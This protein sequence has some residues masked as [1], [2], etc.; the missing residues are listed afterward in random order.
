MNPPVG[1]SEN[2]FKGIV[3][4]VAGGALIT[5]SD[6]IMKIFAGRL[7]PGE[8]LFIRNSFTLIAIAL[9]AL[10]IGSVL[11]LR[12]KN[13]R[14]QA[15]RAGF[16]VVS[17]FLFVAGIEHTPLA[18]A[19]AITFTGPLIVTALAVPM[20]GEQVGWRRWL[21]VAIGFV[22]VVV[23]IRPGTDAFTWGSIFI[24]LGSAGG[25]MRDIITRRL[26]ATET[27]LSILLISSAALALAGLATAPFGW[28]PVSPSDVGLLAVSGLLV[29]SSHYLMI[30]SLRLAEA[31][32]VVPFKYANVIWAIL[33]GY[34]FWQ[35]VPDRWTFVGVAI[36]VA[37]GL[38]ILERE[39]RL[40]R[41]KN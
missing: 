18:N 3:C 16:L 5:L 21:A 11:L 41:R 35:H 19:I 10:K 22:G 20:L 26:C 34:L 25:A 2:A 39:S 12:P 4:M 1:A 7:P 8:I 37:S 33:F 13:I 14:G 29:A 30:E 6:A 36:L 28:K 27:S 24:L 31:A 23:V 9:V 38:Y 40:R 32:V 15:A 17:A